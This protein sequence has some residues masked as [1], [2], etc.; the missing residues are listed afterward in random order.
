MKRTILSLLVVV[1]LA[2][3]APAADSVSP[4]TCTVASAAGGSWWFSTTVPTNYVNPY[5]QIKVTD[6]SGN[7]YIYPWKVLAT[8]DPL[9]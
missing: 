9:D 4:A 2:S 5:L 7:S 6:G 3:A 1:L 8:S